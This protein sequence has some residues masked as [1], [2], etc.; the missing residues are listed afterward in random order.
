MEDNHEQPTPQCCEEEHHQKGQ[1]VV[2]PRPEEE[3]V[4]LETYTLGVEPFTFEAEE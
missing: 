4:K 3:K 2:Q 1:V